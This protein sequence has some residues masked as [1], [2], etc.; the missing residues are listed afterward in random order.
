MVRPTPSTREAIIASSGGRC[1]KCFKLISERKEG[2]INVSIVSKVA[3]IRGKKPGSSRYDDSMSDK[4][5]DSYANLILL[6]ADCHTVVDAQPDDYSVKTLQILKHRHGKKFIRVT[7]NGVPGVTFVE[8]ERVTK[9]IASGRAVGEQT[10]NL[11]APRDKI[12]KNDLSAAVEGMIKMGM[13]RVA[14]VRKYVS[15]QPDI[16]FGMKLRS[17]FVSEYMKMREEGFEGDTLFLMLMGFA[18][19]QNGNES[20]GLAVLVYLFESCEVFEK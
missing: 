15:I 16:E 17:S 10:Y 12:L 4:E 18:A 1:A 2:S 7:G 13:T 11:V 19:G 5:R 20:A 9:Y 14:E 8:L 3:H 6:C